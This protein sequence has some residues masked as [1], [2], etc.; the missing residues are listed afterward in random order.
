MKANIYIVFI[1]LFALLIGGCVNTEKSDYKATLEPVSPGAVSPDKLHDATVIIAKRLSAYGIPEGNIKVEINGEKISLSVIKTE[2]SS[3]DAIK[4][5]IENSDKLEFWETYE[6]SEVI[7]ALAKANSLKPLYGILKPMVDNEGK[8]K[9]T[10]LIGLA[11]GNDTSLVNKYMRE[12]GIKALFPENIRFF[13][14]QNPYRYFP[15]EDLFE[16]HA[17]RVTSD[18]HQAPLNGSDIIDA[19]PKVSN[20]HSSIWLTMSPEGAERWSSITRQNIGRCIAVVLNG[21]VRAYPVVQMEIT[22][23]KTEISGDFTSEEATFFSNVLKSGQL[24]L[25]LRIID[26]QK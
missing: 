11:K 6:N 25:K 4:S 13:W 14:S 22:G 19:S 12:P 21:H 20:T 2:S 8:P 7:D 9:R 10:C 1:L 16:L 24:P 3:R 17:I 26:E 18:D 15:K 5:L 23:G